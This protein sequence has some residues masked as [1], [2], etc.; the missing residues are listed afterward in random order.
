[1]KSSYLKIT[2][3]A[4]AAVLL[5]AAALGGLLQTESLRYGQKLKSLL[6]SQIVYAQ[7]NKLAQ[8]LNEAGNNLG[9]FSMSGNPTFAE[10]FNKANK[11]LPRAMDE[12]GNLGPF[13][14]SE[15][16]AVSQLKQNVSD[17]MQLLAQ[18]RAMISEPQMSNSTMLKGRSIFR[19]MQIDSEKIQVNLINLLPEG[20]VD[21]LLTK[22]RDSEAEEK[23]LRQLTVIWL[24][25]TLLLTAS[26]SALSFLPTYKSSQ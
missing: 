10:K 3:I 4:L 9:R 1:M 7:S 11:A 15:A 2:K 22:L 18:A 19:S 16:E 5:S 17:S 20:G 23:H 24:V 6:H 14:D 21:T 26:L 25:V 13:E 12:L 8:L